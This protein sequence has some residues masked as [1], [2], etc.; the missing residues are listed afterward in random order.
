MEK[1]E[2]SMLLPEMLLSPD[3]S[4]IFLN[5][6]GRGSHTTRIVEDLSSPTRDQTWA[7]GSASAES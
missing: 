3:P 6:L 7:F 5:I 4:F 1:V 2:C